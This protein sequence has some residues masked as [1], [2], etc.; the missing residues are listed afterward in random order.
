MAMN[1]KQILSKLRGVLAKGGEIE[2]FEGVSEL[3]KRHP[4]HEDDWTLYP[5]VGKSQYGSACI[6]VRTADGLMPVSIHNIAYPNQASNK[7]IEDAMRRLV[8]PQIDCFREDHGRPGDH[9]DHVPPTEFRD[10]KAAFLHEH[11]EPKTWCRH[12]NGEW[13]PDIKWSNRW[14]DF[15]AVNAQLQ[16]LSP[17]EHARV[18]KERLR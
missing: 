1:G 4:A 12:L 2:D 9:V 13:W 11:G 16:C 10:L 6:V 7:W 17:E 8:R 3:L 15:H 18:T 5:F 14:L